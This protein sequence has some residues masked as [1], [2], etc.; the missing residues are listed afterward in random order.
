[1][2]PREQEGYSSRLAPCLVA[3]RIYRHQRWRRRLPEE[4][5]EDYSA[6]LAEV[7]VR[8]DRDCLAAEEA[9]PALREGQDCSVDRRTRELQV[10]CSDFVELDRY[11]KM[12]S[13]IHIYICMHNQGEGKRKREREKPS[14][15]GFV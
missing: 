7:L 14:V 4:V 10:R 15:R 13:I 5:Q 8:A 6:T 9:A 11:V 2:R 1:M 3:V 12:K